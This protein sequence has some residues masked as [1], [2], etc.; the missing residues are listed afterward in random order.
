MVGKE[1][2]VKI[3]DEDGDPDEKTGRVTKIST[4]GGEYR[5]MIG[6]EWYL[7]SDVVNVRESSDTRNVWY[8]T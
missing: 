2:T 8:E 4:K 5:L 3:K 6:D 1:V 7:M